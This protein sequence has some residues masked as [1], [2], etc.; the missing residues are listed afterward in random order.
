MMP[1]QN[2]A[3]LEALVLFGTIIEESTLS[4]FY[5]AFV[6]GQFYIQRQAG[7]K[8]GPDQ[9]RP[10]VRVGSTRIASDHEKNIKLNEIGTFTHL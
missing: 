9:L 1:G 7:S 3:V 6:F 5:I 4:Q 8:L 2:V 10:P